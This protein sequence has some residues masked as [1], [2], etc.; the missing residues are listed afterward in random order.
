LL[1]DLMPEPT[2][3]VETFDFDEDF[4]RLQEQLG[5]DLD[6][7][8][9]MRRLFERGGKVIFWHGWAD[10]GVPPQLTLEFH[11]DVLRDAGSQAAAATRLFMVPGVLHC[12]NGTGPD[13]FGQNGSPPPGAAPDTH[14]GAALEAWVEQG[15]TPDTMIAGYGGDRVTEGAPARQRLLCAYPKRAELREGADPNKAGSYACDY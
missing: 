15:R 7:Q 12:G 1:E 6:V 4:T 10:P 3:T 9:H 14:L 13:L 2:A 11:R 8:P 5:P